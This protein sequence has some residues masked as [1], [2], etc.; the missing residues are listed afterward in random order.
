MKSE[1]TSKRPYH[2]P[3]RAAAAAQTYERILAAAKRR[4]ER[5]GWS[6]TT[7]RA[8]A[9]DARVSPKTVEA[10]FATKS[11]VLRAAVDFAIRGDVEPVPMTRRTSVAEMEEAPDAATMLRLYAAH[12][13]RINS[14]SARIAWVVEHAAPG[15]AAVAA[16]W[17]RMNQN[18]RFGV[19]W[20]TK[21][22]FSKGDARRDLSVGEVEAA[23]WVGLDWGTYR[24]LTTYAGL[25]SAEFEEW[26]GA[27]FRALVL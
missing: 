6:G 1:R 10:L 22:F 13:G 2:A 8:I 16:L 24:T 17:R 5:R 19:R 23:F 11:G 20:A 15:D 21:T 26:L 4:F 12:V 27:Y 25:T 18:R 3:S 9:S 7:I 14:R